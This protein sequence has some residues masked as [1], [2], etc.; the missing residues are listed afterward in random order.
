[1]QP[2]K[3]AKGYNTAEQSAALRGQERLAWKG[4]ENRIWLTPT[5]KGEHT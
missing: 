1:M 2:C 3:R 5:A 4:P